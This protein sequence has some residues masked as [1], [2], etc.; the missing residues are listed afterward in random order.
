MVFEEAGNSF[1]KYSTITSQVYFLVKY[2]VEFMVIVYISDITMKFETFINLA[3][4]FIDKLCLYF[5]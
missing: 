2:K 1:L 5:I 4:D 3:L